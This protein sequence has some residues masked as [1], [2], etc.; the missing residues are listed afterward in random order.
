MNAMV[1]PS[2][3]FIHLAT[4]DSIVMDNPVIASQ[5]MTQQEAVYAGKVI[6]MNKRQAKN[7]T[8]PNL[9]KYFAAT[10]EEFKDTVSI[11]KY[12]QIFLK[13]TIFIFLNS[14]M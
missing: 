9:V 6:E 8:K 4:P 3:N 14:I 2:G 7:E 13:K 11:L 5:F 1:G 10:A 12:H